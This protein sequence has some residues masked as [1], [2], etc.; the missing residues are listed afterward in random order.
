MTRVP[1]VASEAA[2]ASSEAR[3]ASGVLVGDQPHADLGGGSGGDH[4]LRT[5]VGEAAGDAVDV[6]GRAGEVALE[7]AVARF[8]FESRR[9][10]DLEQHLLVDWQLLPALEL[11]RRWVANFVVEARDEDPAVAVL[12]AGEEMS[13]GVEGIRNQ[14]AEGARVEVD[15]G[16]GHLD[17]GVEV[18]A[19]PGQELEQRPVVDE[20]VVAP[21]LVGVGLQ[22][23]GQH[24]AATLLLALDQEAEVERRAAG[25]ERVFGRLQRGEVLALVVAGAPGEHRAVTDRRLEGRRDP[26]LERVGRLHVVVAVDRQQRLA[27]C[28]QPV[29]S[30]RRMAVAVLVERGVHAHRAEALDQPLGVA[31]A[32]GGVAAQGADAGYR[33]LLG[34]VGLR[35]RPPLP[36]RASAIAQKQ[37][38]GPAGGPRPPPNGPA[39]LSFRHGTAR[40]SSGA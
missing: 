16:A 26:F 40:R 10:G 38:G 21:Q 1:G 29:G 4:R 17:L 12:Q 30:H 9:A 14:A 31:P 23:V 18:A 24:L 7:D 32:V 22:Q 19:E 36:S 35:P 3:I 2:C 28:A 37:G 34:E 5:L 39:T 33:E 6:E 8:A 20:D 11:F 13:Q 25:G 15:G 27:G